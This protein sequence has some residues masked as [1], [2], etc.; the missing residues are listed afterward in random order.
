MLGFFSLLTVAA[1]AMSFSKED[2]PLRLGR[3]LVAAWQD[4]TGLG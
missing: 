2:R 1:S 3:G 4:A